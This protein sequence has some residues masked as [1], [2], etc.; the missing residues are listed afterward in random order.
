LNLIRVMP[1]KGQ[2]YSD[3]PRAARARHFAEA[4]AM[5]LHD[6]KI[7]PAAVTTG[8]LSGSRKVYSSPEGHDDLRVPLRE[9]G[10]ADGASASSSEAVG[11]KRVFRV[12]DTS[13][14][15]TDADAGIDVARGLPPL[16]APWIEARRVAAQPITQLELAR[17]G[18]VT[19]EMV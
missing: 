4:E 2:E 15:Y 1:A 14:P 17:A 16:R 19:K 3:V 6:K 5:N 12:Y 13:G 10:L 11:Q 8:P 7:A 18:I 9:I